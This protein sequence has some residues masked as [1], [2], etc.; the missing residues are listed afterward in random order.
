MV[1]PGA[2]K[3]GTSALHQALSLHPEICMSSEKEPHFFSIDSVYHKGREFHNSLFPQ[4]DHFRFYGESSTGYMLS[5]KA[6]ARISDTLGRPKIIMVLR[7]PVDRAF[8]HYRWRFK[9]GLEKRDFLR[10]VTESGYGYDPEQLNGWGYASYLQFSRYSRYVPLWRD[11]FG[12][13]NVHLI[14]SECLRR[15]LNGA[16]KGCLSFLGVKDLSI[17]KN[18]FENTT[19]DTVSRPTPVMLTVSRLLPEPLKKTRAYQ[20]VKRA[21]L[22]RLTSEPAHQMTPEERKFVESE[23]ADDVAF[24]RKAFGK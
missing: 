13:N 21:F 20:N 3:S 2:A 23:L 10:A 7:E 1:I 4:G 22:R 15:D 5:E 18:V 9:L 19:E 12:D 14:D 24:Y 16:L 8:S 17:D 6:I 11:E